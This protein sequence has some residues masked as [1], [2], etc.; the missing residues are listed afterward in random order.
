AFIKLIKMLIG[1][2]VFCVVVAG[3]CGAGELKKVGRVG[4]KAVVYFEVVTT[5]ALALGVVLAYV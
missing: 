3:I 1:P 5:I 2:I 4:I